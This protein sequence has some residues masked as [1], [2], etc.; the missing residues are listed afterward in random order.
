MNL[1]HD[2][3]LRCASS[4][5]MSVLF[6][7]AMYSLRTLYECTASFTCAA[8]SPSLS[9]ARTTSPDSLSMTFF[10]IANRAFAGKRDVLEAVWNRMTARKFLWPAPMARFTCLSWAVAVALE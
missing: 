7:C 6:A 3:V 10:A 8:A 5:L 2:T 9:R 4:A 1:V